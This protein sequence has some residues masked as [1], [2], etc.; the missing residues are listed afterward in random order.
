MI[1]DIITLLIVLLALAFLVWTLARSWKA[2]SSGKANS[3]CAACGSCP[4]S[5]CCS[6]QQNNT[7]D[8]STQSE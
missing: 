5:G 6:S 2:A 4:Q 7:L 3:A 1:F 8:K